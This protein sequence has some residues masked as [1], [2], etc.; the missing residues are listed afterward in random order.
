[1]ARIDIVTEQ[2]IVFRGGLGMHLKG[3]EFGVAFGDAAHVVARLELVN[4][5]TYRNAGL[6]PLAGRPVGNVLA[7]PEAT[8]RQLCIQVPGI[9]PDQMCKNLALQ[10]PRQV[11]AR[12]R[13]GD[14]ELWKVAALDAN[15]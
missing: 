14:E 11:G 8:M 15:V 7:S 1:M 2:G 9:R 10:P 4:R 13:S 6:A 3:F 12:R 5:N